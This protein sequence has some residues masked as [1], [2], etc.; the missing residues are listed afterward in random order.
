MCGITGFWDPL[1]QFNKNELEK[2][3]EQMS[4][5]LF[6]RGPDDGGTWVDPEMG[7]ALGHRRLSIVDLSPEGHQPMTSFD[8]RYVMV[9]N[10]EI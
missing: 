8:G 1:Q 10:G 3:T 6:H 2:I 9:F 7:I 4:Q 5:T